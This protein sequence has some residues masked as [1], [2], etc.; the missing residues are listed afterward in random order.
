MTALLVSTDLVPFLPDTK[1]LALDQAFAS[2]AM[3]AMA[4]NASSPLH[5]RLSGKVVLGGHSM[6][7]GTSV[8]A[9]DATF[10]PQAAG[11]DAVALYAPGLYTN[12]SGYSH[13]GR[14]KAPLLVVSGAMDCGPNQLPK[15]ALPLYDDVR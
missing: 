9:A 7:G 10:A 11:L 2:V 6:G 1:D 4:A 12:P 8:L 15:E 5:G 14:V 3:P 13:R